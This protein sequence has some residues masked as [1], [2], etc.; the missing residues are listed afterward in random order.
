M[1]CIVNWTIASV[2]ALSLGSQ[3]QPAGEEPPPLR[4]DIDYPAVVA[5]PAY[6]RLHPRLLFDEAHRNFHT[7]AD[8]YRPFARLVEHD[9]YSLAVN[10]APFTPDSIRGYEILV[11]AN[12]LGPPGPDVYASPAFTEAEIGTVRAWVRSGGSLLLIAD[13]APFGA[14]AASFARAF[15]VDM[16]TGFTVDRGLSPPGDLTDDI[17]FS[18]FNGGLGNHPILQGRNRRERIGTVETFTGQ[19][20]TGPLGSSA[21]LRLSAR[22]TDTLAP[23][24]SEIRAAI[25]QARAEARRAGRPSPDSVSV[26]ASRE[27]SAAG[28]AQA[29]AFRFGRGRV[30]V[31]GEAAMLTAQRDEQDRPVGL[32]RPGIDNAQLALNVMHWLSHLLP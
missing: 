32:N 5:H 7:T 10:R 13:H 12:A 16:S 31:L 6:R 8:R 3:Q 30:V 1:G 15:G 18:R 28:K 2:L 11:V 29:L 27:V 22:A 9:G 19:S 17:P 21:L 4:T 23:T 14:A 24:P 20:L 25:A 26:P